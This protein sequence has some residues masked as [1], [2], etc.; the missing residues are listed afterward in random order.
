[1]Q[2]SFVFRRAGLF[3][4]TPRYAVGMVLRSKTLSL[5]I[6]FIYFVLFLLACAL[7]V[8]I[9]AQANKWIK[10]CFGSP[11]SIYKSAIRS[12]HHSIFCFFIFVQEMEGEKLVVMKLTDRDFLRSLE[13]A[14]CR[15]VTACETDACKMHICSR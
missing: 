5:I 15:V 1:M 9:Q 14:V 12:T 2:A 4:L 3:L 13:N 11:I 7:I 8:M 6:F 10:V